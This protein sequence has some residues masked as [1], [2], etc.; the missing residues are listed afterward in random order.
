MLS[1]VESVGVVGDIVESLSVVVILAHE[2][3]VHALVS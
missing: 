1:A 3:S 2:G